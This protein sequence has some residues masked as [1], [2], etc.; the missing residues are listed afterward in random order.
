V[1][2]ARWGAHVSGTTASDGIDLVGACQWMSVCNEGTLTLSG[3]MAGSRPR[4]G[5]KS[6]GPSA[7][8]ASRDREDCLILPT[9]PLPEDICAR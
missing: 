5:E 8:R 6:S 2:I 4:V 9:P 1:G 7:G 3:W